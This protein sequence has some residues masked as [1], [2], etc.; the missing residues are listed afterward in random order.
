[1]LLQ[2]L[3][4]KWIFLCLL[5][6][7]AWSIT[8]FGIYARYKIKSEKGVRIAAILFFFTGVFPQIILG[9]LNFIINKK[10]DVFTLVV[11][12]VLLYGATVGRKQIQKID[13]WIKRKI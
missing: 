13:R 1:M 2:I 5:E 9:I 11:V 3:D 8:F 10:I 7:T 6:V 4:Y 12:G